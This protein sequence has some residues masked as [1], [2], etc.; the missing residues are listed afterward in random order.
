[1]EY[2]YKVRHIEKWNRV[3]SRNKPTYNM[4]NWFSQW[5]QDNPRERIDFF[6]RNGTETATYQYG[7]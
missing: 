1:M 4:F 3:E 7:E 6:S 2:L 5:Y